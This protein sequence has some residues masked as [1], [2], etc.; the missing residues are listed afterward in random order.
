MKRKKQS[1]ERIAK[2][3]ATQAD[4]LQTLGQVTYKIGNRNH[5]L[6]FRKDPLNWI[7]EHNGTPH[8]YHKFGSF[9]QG[10]Y[11]L[12][13][14]HKFNDM[15]AAEAVKANDFAHEMIT[16]L[17]KYADDE[18]GRLD[19]ENRELRDEVAKLNDRLKNAVGGK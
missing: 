18:I 5:E 12:A 13:K 19:S 9:M 4:N 15:G 7:I 3:L 10:V 17:T 11:D 16:E 8:Y 2:R 14:R 1:P 6:V